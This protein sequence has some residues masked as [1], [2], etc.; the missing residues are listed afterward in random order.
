MVS[1]ETIRKAIENMH[2]I[3]KIGNGEDFGDMA[4]FLLGEKK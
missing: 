4:S 1:N 2:P 3:P